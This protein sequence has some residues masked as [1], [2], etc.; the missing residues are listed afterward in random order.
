MSPASVHTPNGSDSRPPSR[1]DSMRSIATI[2]S[3][4]IPAY[5]KVSHGRRFYSQRLGYSPY[6]LPADPREME[7]LNLQHETIKLLIAGNHLGPVEEILA[8]DQGG[9]QRVVMD[10]GTGSGIWV[11]Q[12]AHA[13]PHVKF[14]GVDLVPTAT[15]YPPEHVRFECYN[16]VQHNIRHPDASVDFVHARFLSLGISNYP[17]LLNEIARVL[18][19]GGLFFSGEWDLT[20]RTPTGAALSASW[21]TIADAERMFIRA[22]HDR[23]LGDIA[24]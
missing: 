11:E 21:R 17:G 3:D 13:F 23:E 6:V 19:P 16:F 5:Y 12:M 10:L 1:A 9:R 2:E 24:A 20:H 22:L 15:S 4:E 14:I 8:S 7:R 18:R